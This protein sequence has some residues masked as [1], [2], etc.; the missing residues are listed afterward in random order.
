MSETARQRW[1]GIFICLLLI[2]ALAVSM[3]AP[4]GPAGSDRGRDSLVVGDEAPTFVVLNALTEDAVF[5]RDFTGKEIRKASK[6]RIR[7]VV[8]VSFWASWC[9]PCKTEI[10]LLTKMA[11]EF[12]DSPVKIFLMNTMESLGFTEDSVRTVLKNRG[13]TLPCLVDNTGMVARR[14]SVRGLPMI[15]VIDKFGIIRKINR[16]FHENFDVDIR[17]LVKE[18][19]KEDHPEQSTN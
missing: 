11:A 4:A 3:D 7:H 1:I 12:K 9:E 14:Y 18:L 13:Y 6:N 17:A 16:G 15:V 8:I 2:P 5:L 19:L 10:P